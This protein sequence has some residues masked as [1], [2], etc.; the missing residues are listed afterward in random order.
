MDTPYAYTVIFSASAIQTSNLRKPSR[1]GTV[2][3]NKKLK[4]FLASLPRSDQV[5][6]CRLI[7]LLEQQ[8][9]QHRQIALEP[10]HLDALGLSAQDFLKFSQYLESLAHLIDQ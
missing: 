9:V 6:L 7:S 3:D 2:M 1:V 8:L 10:P 4:A 5:T